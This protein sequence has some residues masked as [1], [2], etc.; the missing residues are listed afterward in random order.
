VAS[1]VTPPPAFADPRTVIEAAVISPPK[2]E[3]PETWAEA[4]AVVIAPDDPDTD[5]ETDAAWAIDPSPGYAKLPPTPTASGGP[6]TAPALAP[7][8]PGTKT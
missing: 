7:P 4:L 3:R 8:W 5:D 2:S 6:V 1:P